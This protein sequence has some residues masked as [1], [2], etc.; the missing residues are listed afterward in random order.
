MS[1]LVTNAALSSAWIAPKPSIKERLIF[2]TKFGDRIIK[3]LAPLAPQHLVEET[4]KAEGSLRGKRLRILA[5]QVSADPT[6]RQLVLEIALT[7]NVADE[8]KRGWQNDIENFAYMSVLGLEQIQCPVLLIHGDA[9]TDV[10]LD[11][12]ESAHARLPI[13]ELVVMSDGT[14]LSFY[15]HPQA[16]DI[17]NK[18]KKWFLQHARGV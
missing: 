18:A 11:H 12:S 5:K 1:A 8:R 9:N 14:H 16:R 7:V 17:Q 4:L 3:F 2:G 6:Q 10:S 15:A 13:S